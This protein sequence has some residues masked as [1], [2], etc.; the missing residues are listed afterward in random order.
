MSEHRLVISLDLF[1][2][3][4]PEGIPRNSLVILA[5]KG[6][7]GKSAIVANIAKNIVEN[8]EPVVYV[9]LDDDPVT[10]VE[11]LDSFGLKVEEAASSRLLMLVDGFSYLIKGRRERAHPAVVEEVDPRNPDN[12]ASAVLRVLESTGLKGRGL[13]IIDSLN[14]AMI[15]LDPT[16]FIEFVKF[17]RANVSK[18]LR[19]PVIATLHTS[20]EGFEEYLYTI[21]HLVD[22]LIET[23]NLEEGLS[24]QLPMQ[25]RQVIIRKIKGV[26]HRHGWVLYTI[27]K[28]GVKP[29]ILKVEK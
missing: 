28:T 12:V 14:E 13:V 26:S 18:A 10:I 15:S 27:D 1:L 16:R 17:L 25:V 29:V 9:G 8:G 3:I 4:L 24:S 22:G 21:E 7:S 20:T 5:G 2:Y 23:Q 11:Q 6:G 19:V